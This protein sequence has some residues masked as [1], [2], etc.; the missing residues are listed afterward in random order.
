MLVAPADIPVLR[1]SAGWEP[2]GR[3]AHVGRRRRQASG[4]NVR[5]WL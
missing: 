3:I 1:R 4:Y 5:A 2:E